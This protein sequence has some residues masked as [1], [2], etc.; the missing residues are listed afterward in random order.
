VSTQLVNLV[1][2]R[3]IADRRINKIDF[4][5]RKYN[6]RD[7]IFIYSRV[8][9]LSDTNMY[10]SVYFARFFDLQGES[11]E[12]FLQYF[13]G[14]DLAEFAKKKYGI[15]T[16]KANCQYKLPLFVY[17]KV[18]ILLQV[19][20]LKRTKFKLEFIVQKAETE[21]TAAIGEQWIG[22]TNAFGLPI[23]IPQIVLKNLKKYVAV[24]QEVAC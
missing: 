8:I 7:R 6:R 2:E 23:P 4:S 21:K 17:D 12:E 1:N 15:V 22:F 19:T 16:V 11:R 18:D 9:H 5:R 3:R 14:D 24:K 13:M 10:G 20:V